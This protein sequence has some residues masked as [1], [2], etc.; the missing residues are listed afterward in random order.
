MIKLCRSNMN[1][2]QEWP[3]PIVRVQS[4]SESRLDAIPSRYVKPLLERPLGGLSATASENIDIP[5][6]DLGGLSSGFGDTKGHCRLSPLSQQQGT[7]TTTA[8]MKRMSEAC[9]EWGFFQVVNHGIDGDVMDRAR[10]V[11][12]EFFKLPME[13]KQ[14]YA[15]SPS[16]YEGY[17]SRLG[18][19]KGAILDW[20][21]YYFLHYLPS[22]IRDHGKWPSQ[23]PYHREITEQYLQ[24]VTQLGTTLMKLLSLNLGLNPKRLLDAFGGEDD[25]G[26]CLRV[27]FY[28][29]CPQPDLTL[30]L[31]SHSDPGGMTLLLP[32]PNV[33]GLQVRKDG[34]WV[35]V[36]PEPHA[37]I[38]NIGDQIQVLSNGMYKSVEHR[39]IVNPNQERVSLALF[40][41]P[42]ADLLIQPIKEL[43]T[44]ITPSLY[45]PM[46]FNEYRLF[47]R[48][49]GPSGKSHVESLKKK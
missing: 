36:K 18:V 3:E 13:A 48:S 44:S 16:T 9:K 31:S 4:L 10:E 14:R 1:C 7:K 23:P 15:N 6:I 29:R 25:I 21:D 46:T 37:F 27:N 42:R 38:V 43:V 41:N 8:M 45:S 22:E 35:T 24:Q 2:L 20:S 11:W 33:P 12:R 19:E 17:G 5:V 30:G 26:A 32:D 34:K 47:I 39:V 49:R 40:Y 28:P